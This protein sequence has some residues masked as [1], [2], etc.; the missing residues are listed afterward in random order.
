MPCTCAG[1]SP[2]TVF[3]D[4]VRAIQGAV[5]DHMARQV[6][7]ASSHRWLTS[8]TTGRAMARFSALVTEIQKAAAGGYE[9]V[10]A[11]DTSVMA[12]VIRAGIRAERER[13]AANALP[14]DSLFW[15]SLEAMRP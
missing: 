10:A 15:P 3:V 11:D 2:D 12:T 7:R 14:S 8:T 9:L 5:R 4:R 1:C 6:F 13:L